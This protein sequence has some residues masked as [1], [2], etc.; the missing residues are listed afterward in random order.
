MANSC[1]QEAA[2]TLLLLLQMAIIIIIGIGQPRQ[3]EA[4]GLFLLWPHKSFG[5]EGS[6]FDLVREAC[7]Q[8]GAIAAAAFSLSRVE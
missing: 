7:L 1:C 8:R 6:C 4:V 2:I 5:L 3:L